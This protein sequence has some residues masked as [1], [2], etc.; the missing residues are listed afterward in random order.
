MPA[1][2][3]PGS[4]ALANAPATGSASCVCR[5]PSQ[6]PKPLQPGYGVCRAERGKLTFP[7]LLGRG[8]QPGD[9]DDDLKS[10]DFPRH[11]PNVEALLT[12]WRA[13]FAPVLLGEMLL[14]LRMLAGEEGAKAVRSFVHGNGAKVSHAPDSPLSGMAA[15]S[16]QFLAN[17]LVVVLRIK[18]NVKK[19]AAGGKAPDFSALRVAIPATHWG[20]RDF[21]AK[22]GDPEDTALKAIV[23]G[24]QGEELWATALRHDPV[25]RTYELRLRWVILDHFGVSADDL[26]AP[27]LLP[28]Y[29]LQHERK[30]Y[31]PFVN[32]LVI[33]A[34]VSGS[35]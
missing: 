23:G 35:Y 12:P 29:V 33:G 3:R 25:R 30:G 28:F 27:G 24:T 19:L 17:F 26:Y 11:E 1:G 6:L 22:F 31:R 20:L 16:W 14:V 5:T 2:K 9:G 18:A 21:P 32:E 7:L 34:T 8:R 10:Y 15:R 4:T 13:R